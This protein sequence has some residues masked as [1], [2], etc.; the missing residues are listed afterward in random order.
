MIRTEKEIKFRIK[1]LEKEQKKHYATME[2]KYKVRDNLELEKFET[3][4]EMYYECFIEIN[5]LKWVLGV[6]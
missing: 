3:A 4:Q 1:F 2:K 6:Q 5:T